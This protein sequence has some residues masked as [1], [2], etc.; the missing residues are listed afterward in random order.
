M[1]TYS[2][3]RTTR[4]TSGSWMPTR[5]GRPD[6]W[7]SCREC[8]SAV[9]R[10]RVVVGGVGAVIRRYS[11]RRRSASARASRS[12]SEPGAAAASR[13]S[14]ARQSARTET[15]SR[16][17]GV[18]RIGWSTATS[19]AFASW[20]TSS[21][22][23]TCWPP[24]H[25]SARDEVLDLAREAHELGFVRRELALAGL[26]LVQPVEPLHEHVGR[27][28]QVGGMLEL[29]VVGEFGHWGAPSAAASTSRGRC[30]GV[31]ANARRT[32]LASECRHRQCIE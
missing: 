27:L 14:A 19:F 30:D 8:V 28:P 26:E 15:A 20:W 2:G 9:R 18:S 23:S 17:G 21:A 6:R 11:S 3:Q 32:H 29:G 16:R 24:D 10:S 31:R 25:S 1:A 7:G 5:R 13:R 4:S 12:S 22:S